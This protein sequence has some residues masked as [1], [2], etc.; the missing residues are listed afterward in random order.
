MYF[1]SMDLNHTYRE[2]EE[3]ADDLFAAG[4]QIVFVTPQTHACIYKQTRAVI[5]A[6]LSLAHPQR[7]FCTNT[8]LHRVL[9]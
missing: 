9:D 4:L 3:L 5:W 1:V 6:R 8:R 2:K 7:Y